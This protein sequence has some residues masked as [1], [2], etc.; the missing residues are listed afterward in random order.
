MCEEK[1]ISES[2]ETIDAIIYTFE[3]YVDSIKSVPLLKNQKIKV[4]RYY[5][6]EYKL[7]ITLKECPRNPSK[8]TELL[9]IIRSECIR[10]KSTHIDYRT[11][12]KPKKENI[13][14]CKKWV[15]KC[16]KICEYEEKIKTLKNEI[17][18]TAPENNLPD[19]VADKKFEEGIML[20]E[21]N[22]LNKSRQNFMDCL[23]LLKDN[24]YLETYNLSCYNISCS[25]AKEGKIQEA[26]TWLVTAIKYGYRNWSHTIT[27][28]D[29]EKLVEVP[30]FAN[31]IKGMMKMNPY[32][33]IEY[34]DIP[35]EYNSVDIFL[36]RNNLC[37]LEKHLKI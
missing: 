32:R 23:E 14:L 34:V 13:K 18:I 33:N 17:F 35:K 5:V 21:I 27:D 9:E 24:P 4:F 3:E 8:N 11:K 26:L 22:E 1:N 25:Y 15:M 19:R 37:K 2:E 29:M 20:L 36:E 30:Y 31:I 10:E 16:E 12:Y 6:P 7:E 28:K